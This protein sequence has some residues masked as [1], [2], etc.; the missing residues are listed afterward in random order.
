MEKLITII[1]KRGVRFLDYMAQYDKK[2]HK[3]PK[4]K[5]KV[6]G[7]D[8]FVYDDKELAKL[9]KND[10]EARYI[11]IFETEDI[12]EIQKKLERLGLSLKNFYRPESQISAEGQKKEAKKGKKTKKAKT[13]TSK[14]AGA[15]KPLYVVQN[16]K[17][18]KELFSLKDVLALVREHAQK[19][20]HIQRYKGLGEMNPLQLWETTMD[21]ARRTLLKVTL[22]DAVEVDKTFSILM[23]DEVAPRRQFIEENAHEVKDLDI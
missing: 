23:G 8:R 20:M 17:D 10:E 4:Y 9:T 22:E 5:A 3:L 12:I 1:K 7:K 19:G 15:L 21:P 13:S 18:K 6:E 2:S 11:E 16:D 14:K